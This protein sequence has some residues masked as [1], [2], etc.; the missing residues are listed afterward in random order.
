MAHGY[1]GGAVGLCWCD[2]QDVTIPGH[3]YRDSNVY[4]LDMGDRRF[5]RGIEEAIYLKSEN[6]N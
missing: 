5:E 1:G 4:I 6:R 2:I 3:S